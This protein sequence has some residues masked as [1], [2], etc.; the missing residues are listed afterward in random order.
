M[1]LVFATKDL[2]LAGRSFEGFSL[3]IGL[4]GW[5]VEPVQTFLW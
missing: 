1:R 2:S 4:D 3:L 5:P